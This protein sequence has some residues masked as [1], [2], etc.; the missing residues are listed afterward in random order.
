MYKWR[1]VVEGTASEELDVSSGVPQGSVLG[2][3]S[4]CFIS[5]I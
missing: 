1:V 3:A 5:M 2:R 4:F